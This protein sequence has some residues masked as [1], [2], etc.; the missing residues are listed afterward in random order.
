MKAC[1]AFCSFFPPHFLLPSSS[2]S[3]IIANFTLRFRHL[4]FFFSFHRHEFID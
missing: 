3:I 1:N 4:F 2:L